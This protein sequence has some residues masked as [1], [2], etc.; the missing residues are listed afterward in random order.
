MVGRPPRGYNQMQYPLPH[1][2]QMS[3]GLSME[4][5]TRNTVIIPLIRNSELMVGI[6]NVEVNPRHANFAEETGASCFTGSIVP[7]LTVQIA[8]WIPQLIAFGGTPGTDT[9]TAVRF[10][11]F[12]IYMAFEDMYDADNEKDL[13][14]VQ[15]VLELEHE[16]TDKTGQPLLSGVD[17]FSNG[18]SGAGSIP[19]NT[20]GYT[21]VGATHWGATTDAKV[22]SVA[23][24]ELLYWDMIHFGTM[25]S[26]LKKAT[27]N[28]RNVNVQRGRPYYFHSSNYSSPIVKRINPYTFCGIMIHVPQAS[29]AAG[30]DETGQAAQQ[31]ELTPIEHIHFSARV[32]YD[33]WN[34]NFDQTVV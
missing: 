9:A 13:V 10:K 15:S 32:R 23:F 27:G 8:A 2:F 4:D 25:S 22:E 21:E 33:E 29:V 31:G 17:V 5:E 3:F 24:D 26:M 20:V 14:D 16:V 28:I 19:L 7:R 6:E 34:P 11:I 1:N 12:P 30:V 18:A